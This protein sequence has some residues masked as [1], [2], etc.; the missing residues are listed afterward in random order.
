MDVGNSSVVGEALYVNGA[1]LIS[2][3]GYSGPGGA[4]A[5]ASGDRLILWDDGSNKYAIGINGGTLWFQAGT[6]GN[7]T[8]TSAAGGWLSLAGGKITVATWDPVY[9]IGGKQYAT[10]GTGMTGQKEE[11]AGTATL[12]K[13]GNGYAATLDLAGA[14]KGSDLWLFANAANLASNFR[15]VAVL[16]LP[17]F[18][19]DVW[20]EKDVSRETLTIRGSAAGQ[21]SYRLTAP[22]FDAAN[23]PNTAHTNVQGLNLDKYLAQ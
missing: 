8:L 7:M 1:V 22:R 10:Y 11:T 17:S 4:G 18:D 15:Q 19:G 2:N 5:I 13:Q 16:L 9:T 6:S 20:Y 23:W 3:G 21:V 12:T 14:P